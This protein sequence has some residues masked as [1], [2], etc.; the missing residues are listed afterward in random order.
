MPVA[1]IVT[2][3]RPVLFQASYRT[4]AKSETSESLSPAPLRENSAPRG[5]ILNA[6]QRIDPPHESN[7][8]AAAMEKAERRESESLPAASRTEDEPIGK[9]FHLQADQLAAHLRNR[10]KELDHREAELNSRIARFESETRAAR[11]WLD[12]RDADAESRRRELDQR[13]KDLAHA[14]EEMEKRLARLASAEM[15]F[16]KQSLPVAPLPVEKIVEKIVV[17]PADPKIAQALAAKQRQLDETEAKLVEIQ[18]ETQRLHGELVRRQKAFDEE[19]LETR[20]QLA[21]ERQQTLAELEKKRKVV[22]RRA[23]HVDRSR[24]ALKQ[25]REDLGHM[26][27]ETLEIRL[28]TEELWMQLSGAAPPAALTRSLGR[29]RSKL[30]EQY[31][32]ATVELTDQRKE[33]ETLRETLSRQYEKLVEQKRHFENWFSRQQE[34]CQQQATRLVARETQ[35]NH[36]ELRLSE[37]TQ[38]WQSERLKYQQELRR[39]RMAC[40]ERVCETANS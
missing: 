36:E 1:R 14:R 32:Q 9:Q 22:Q 39:L 21:A 10:Q 12:Q 15:A 17:Q 4:M 8:A 18:A 35:L 11:I 2:R 16:Q 30:A 33:L 31:H 29:I 25:V 38:R 28:A 26:H 6:N 40:G 3:S 34:E 23:D 19:A 13:E 5:T 20:R 7:S 27:R 24:A 37:R